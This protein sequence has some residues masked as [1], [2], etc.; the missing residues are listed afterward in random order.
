MLKIFKISGDFVND[1][2]HLK[3]YQD[4]NTGIFVAQFILDNMERP[5]SYFYDEFESSSLG[6]IESDCLQKLQTNPPRCFG[7]ATEIYFKGKL[8]LIASSA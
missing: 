1:V 5:C 3:I 4:R 7:K 2:A 6:T 8:I